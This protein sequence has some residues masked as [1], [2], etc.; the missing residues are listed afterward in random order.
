M[1]FDKF[2]LPLGEQT[3]L[4]SIVSRLFTVVDGPVIAVASPD[5]KQEVELIVSRIASDRLQMAV[6]QQ[7]AGPLEGIRAGLEK[8]DKESAWAFV[9]SCDVPLIEGSV[10]EVLQNAI[11]NGASD[12]E[13]VIPIRGERYFGMTALYRCDAHQKIVPMIEKGQLRVSYLATHLNSV[14]IDIE[15]VQEADPQ[16]DSIRNLNSPNQ[17]VEFLREKGFEC[18]PDFQQQLN[19]LSDDPIE[20]SK[21]SND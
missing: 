6:D 12:I 3:F 9:T 16:L 7:D 10:L 19:L 18:L 11:E 17:Y 2:R 15:K 4:E 8:A 13:A 14:L 21:Q 20:N 5:T 1:G